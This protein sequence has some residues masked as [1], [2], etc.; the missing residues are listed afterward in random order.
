VSEGA[1]LCR[2]QFRKNVGPVNVYP[3][4]TVPTVEIVCLAPGSDEDAIEFMTTE[5]VQR[6]MEAIRAAKIEEFGTR[7]PP[8]ADAG[9]QN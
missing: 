2:A 8:R 9:T 7:N 6:L 3:E 4:W 1:S 5:V